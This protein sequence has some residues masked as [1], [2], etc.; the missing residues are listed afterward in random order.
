MQKIVNA[1]ALLSFAVSA[2]VVGAG[3]YV[4]LNRDAIKAEVKERVTEGIKEAIGDQLSLPLGDA[5][6]G[7]AIPGVGGEEGKPP[8]ALPA[9]P[10]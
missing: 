9:M 8:V 5:D 10:F 2:S 1:L 6:Y 3:A 4:Y 7:A